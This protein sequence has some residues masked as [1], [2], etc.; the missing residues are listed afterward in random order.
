MASGSTAAWRQDR[1]PAA[2]AAA[3]ARYAAEARADVS[4]GSASAAA[5]ID[6]TPTPI[7]MPGHDGRQR[8]NPA[9]TA[10][11]R[12]ATTIADG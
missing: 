1:R 6:A 5:K 8:F 11:V 3:A 7:S 12:N 10:M 2:P 9:M 4:T